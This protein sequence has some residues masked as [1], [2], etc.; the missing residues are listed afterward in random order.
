[1][2]K[3]LSQ[4]DTCNLGF[5]SRTRLSNLLR[6]AIMSQHRF[7]PLVCLLVL[8]SCKTRFDFDDNGQ[9]LSTDSGSSG[10][11][12]GADANPEPTDAPQTDSGYSYEAC[13]SL[14]ARHG[15]SC[16]RDWL[17]CVECNDN[18]DC[19][20]NGRPPYCYEHR[21]I[22]CL[23]NGDCP[24]SEPRTCV[25]GECRPGCDSPD[26]CTSVGAKDCH[27][28][29]CCSCYNDNDCPASAAKHCLL[30]GWY[31][32]ACTDDT[33]CGGATPRCHPSTHTCVACRDGRDCPSGCCDTTTHTCDA[34]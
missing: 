23:S 22:Q 11:G 12:A 20:H 1:M 7:F 19:R 25:F 26:D 21:C 3:L 16:E 18:D 34:N 4:S 2:G 30:P 33:Q 10:A 24:G 13:E 5:G 29:V 31:C 9:K 6:M 32:V 17:R 8:A 14:C 28:R 15:Q 27:D